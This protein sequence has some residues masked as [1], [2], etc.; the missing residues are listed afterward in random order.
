MIY[1]RPDVHKKFIALKLVISD[2]VGCCARFVVVTCVGYAD[3]LI[4]LL[5][6]DVS[7]GG[8]EVGGCR[9]NNCDTAMVLG[10]RA[11]SQPAHI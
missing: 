6:L 1:G 7:S 5:L 2:R 10:K 4:S 3:N 11:A 9:I 8:H